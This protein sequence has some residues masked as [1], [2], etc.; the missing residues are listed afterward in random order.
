MTKMEQEVIALDVICDCVG[1]IVNRDT[2]TIHGSGI[3]VEMQFS[4]RSA[5]RLSSALI[6][7]LLEP[8][9]PELVGK[10]ESVPAVLAR[11]SADPQFDH[12]DSVGDLRTIE[13]TFNEW[14]GTQI[15]V[16]A[17]VQDLDD[18]VQFTLS[19]QEFLTICGN[20]SKHNRSRLTRIAGKLSVILSRVDVG[21]DRLMVLRAL[22]D[23]YERFLH[24]VFSHMTM[25]LMEL[26]NN[27]R[28]GIQEY[29][30]P[31]YLKALIQT[32][33]AME[34]SYRIPTGI[35]H[36]LAQACY[37]NLLNSVRKRPICDRFEVRRL[38]EPRY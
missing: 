23:L 6:A 27:V 33:G 38:R 16:S 28:W 19:R 26:L 17:C 2:L 10:V 36:P 25:P 4:S 21:L 8:M 18:P 12:S 14:L 31:E 7:D 34:Y 9:S 22:D 30:E 20:I 35:Q 1:A 15:T 29:L 32:P 13:R 5:A 11:I 24:E 37:W 3:G